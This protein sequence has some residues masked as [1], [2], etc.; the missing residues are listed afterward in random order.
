[1]DWVPL[2]EGADEVHVLMNTNRL[3]QGSV[4]ARRTAGRVFL[5]KGMD[6]IDASIATPILFSNSPRNVT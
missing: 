6:A 3:D 1:M 4:N 5:S 2:S